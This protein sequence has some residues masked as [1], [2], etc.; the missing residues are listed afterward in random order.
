VEEGT[1][2]LTAKATLADKS[3]MSKT[4]EVVVDRSPPIFTEVPRSSNYVEGGGHLNFRV[5]AQDSQGTPLHFSWTPTLGTLGTAEETSTTSQLVWTAPSCVEPGTVASFTVTVTNALNLSASTHFSAIGFPDCP[6]WSSSS[7]MTMSRIRHRATLLPSGKVLVTG[8]TNSIST[9]EVYDPTLD[10][11][12]PAGNMAVSGVG[13][14]ATLLPSGK[15]L[16]TGGISNHIPSNTAEVYNPTKDT[17]TPASSLS[18]GRYFHTATLLPSGKVLVTGGSIP[19]EMLSTA[20]IYDPATDIWASTGSMITGRGSHTATLLPSGKVLV[21]GG[22]GND[23]AFLATSEVYDPATGVWTPT[24][25]MA[26]GRRLHSA[27]LLPS[28]RV[29]V[30]RLT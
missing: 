17:W 24:G 8:D 29:L 6:K 9:A 22:L 3:F 20:E 26:T 12:T 30:R 13:S 7:S 23:N 14:T 16:V 2:R 15:V 4:H 28:G 18:T 1:H 25:S 10:T 27:T 5:S 21:T 19:G 11:W